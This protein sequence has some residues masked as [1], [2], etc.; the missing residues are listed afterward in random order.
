MTNNLLT[1]RQAKSLFQAATK[2]YKKY[3][4]LTP[5]VK[6]IISNL[7]K[8]GIP[9]LLA[10]VILIHTYRDYDFSEFRHNLSD[11][12]LWWLLAALSFSLLSPGFRGLRWKQLLLSVGHDVPVLDSISIV[13]TGYATN[14]I[15]PRVGEISRCA[16][17]NKHYQVPFGKGIGTL[18]AERF[19]DFILLVTISLTTF[20]LQFRQF[21]S[22]F[23]SASGTQVESTGTTGG[24]GKSVVM[25]IAVVLVVLLISILWRKRGERFVE[26]LKKFVLDIWLGFLALRKVRDIPLFLFYS[27]GI[28]LCYYLELYIAFY[29]LESTA[30]LGAVAGLVCFV[31]SS[32]AVLI[33]TPNGAGPWHVA[34]IVMLGLYGV[35]EQDAQTFALVLHTAQTATFILGGVVGW[36]VLHFLHRR[37]I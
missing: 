22:F 37:Q 25:I 8:V 19:V 17:L 26:R 29:C 36:I 9:L 34:I 30:G 27:L 13:F 32:F 18:M 6:K 16:I 11:F 21:V 15:I 14:I 1:L 31:V 3:V 33:P 12:N 2:V 10:A 20:I 4:I 28:W 35:P 23:K 5:E 7:L 24:I